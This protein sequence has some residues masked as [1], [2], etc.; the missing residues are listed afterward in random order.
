MRLQLWIVQITELTELTR[1]GV[2]ARRLQLDLACQVEVGQL[3]EFVG[4]VATGA[5]HTEQALKLFDFA[6][7]CDGVHIGFYASGTLVAAGCASQDGILL[8]L[9]SGVANDASIECLQ[10][11]L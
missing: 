9:I 1:I 3:A 4:G 11:I 7:L 2:L 8:K 10:H 6:E 5:A